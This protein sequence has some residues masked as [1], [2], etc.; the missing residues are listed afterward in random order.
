MRALVA[1]ALLLALAAPALGAGKRSNL[2][3]GIAALE[4]GQYFAARA[5]LERAMVANPRDPEPYYR[6]GQAYAGMDDDA[7]ALKYLGLALEL[8]PAHRGALL[9]QGR[10]WL[11]QGARDEAARSLDRLDSA[12]GACMEA[13]ALRRAL[14]GGG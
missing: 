13:K 8:E 7:R 12:C 3:A 11:R 14:A 2:A 1:V 6:L 9:A 4:R 10:A 5:E